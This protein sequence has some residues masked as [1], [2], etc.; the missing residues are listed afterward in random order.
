M[1]DGYA[2]THQTAA[3]AGIDE[4]ALFMNTT[5][6]P[7]N[8]GGPVFRPDPPRV[9]GVVHGNSSAERGEEIAGERRRFGVVLKAALFAR[10]LDKLKAAAQQRE[11]AGGEPWCGIP[12]PERNAR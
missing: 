3:V 6:D 11:E 9:V 4:T 1:P 7:G 8:S 2:I 12:A 10:H 5:F